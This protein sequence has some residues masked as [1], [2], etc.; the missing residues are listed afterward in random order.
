[1]SGIKGIGQFIYYSFDYI[2]E[3]RKISTCPS[4]PVLLVLQGRL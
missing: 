1:M 2:L 3:A 4:P